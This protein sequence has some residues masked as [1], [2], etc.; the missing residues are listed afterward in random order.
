MA[1]FLKTSPEAD[2]E[3][4]H[5]AGCKQKETR[6]EGKCTREEEREKQQK[7]V[8]ASLLLCVCVFF[9]VYV[10]LTSEALTRPS[11]KEQLEGSWVHKL[12][13]LHQWQRK[14]LFTHDR[15]L[16]GHTHTQRRK[17]SGKSSTIKEGQ[18]V[19]QTGGSV[20]E[21]MSSDP[22]WAPAVVVPLWLAPY[23]IAAVPSSPC[24]YFLLPYINAACHVWIGGCILA[25]VNRIRWRRREKGESGR[26]SGETLSNEDK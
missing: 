3:L 4:E 1:V 25:P 2:T 19:C 15:H 22:K 7:V 13:Y 23:L 9:H 6:R 26:L 18:R 16:H 10:W 17:E 20:T 5:R 21:E 24:I 14:A 8:Q 11:W 12:R